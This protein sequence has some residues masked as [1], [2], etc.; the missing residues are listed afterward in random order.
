MNV[1]MLALKD[2]GIPGVLQNIPNPPRQL[3]VA[4]PLDEL[5]NR[6]CL[7]IV[8]SRKVSPYGKLVTQTLAETTARHGIVIL[9][10][11]AIGAD[12][13][14]HQA[15]LDAGGQ[16]IA[17]LPAGLERIYPAS[18]QQ[19][20]MKILDQGGALVTEYPPG[21][22]PYPSN[23]LAR[24]RIVSGLSDG[25]LITE[26]AERSGTLATANFA[27]EQG[28]SVMAV[29]GNVNSLLSVGTNN[30]I[31]AGATPVTKVE[32]IFEA[33]G[34][35]AIA[36]QKEVVANNE[37]EQRI[38]ELMQ[39]GLTDLAELQQQSTL[40]PAIFNQ[41]LTMLEISGRVRPIGAGQFTL[42]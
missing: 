10:G 1:K 18:H 39:N 19:L 13:V 20:A 11:L 34:L 6:P 25:V 37:A 38:L 15:A 26:A 40:A 4:G 33:L 5:L 29:P 17:V 22:E 41:T 8:G 30:L 27:L 31:K 7:A 14:A 2:I 23:F 28:R 35:E 12:G 21:S 3:F 42:R 24:N 36:T 9:S 32:D 16:T